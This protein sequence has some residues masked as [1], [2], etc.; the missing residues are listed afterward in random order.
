LSKFRG[1]FHSFDPVGFAIFPIA[2]PRVTAASAMAQPTLPV[3]MM[4][5]FMDSV[6]ALC[7]AL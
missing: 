4:A 1:T 5:S 3:P 2:L 6:S 7:R